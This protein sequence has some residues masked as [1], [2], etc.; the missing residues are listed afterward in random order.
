LFTT[1]SKKYPVKSFVFSGELFNELGEYFSI[2][3]PS[4]A[5]LCLDWWAYELLLIGSSWLGTNALGA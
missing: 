4:M 2:A 1:T 5:L 3:L